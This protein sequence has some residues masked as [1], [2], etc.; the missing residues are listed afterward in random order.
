MD[1]LDLIKGQILLLELED[2]C[3]IG[4]ILHIGAKKSFVRL[5]NVRDFQSNLP[6][7]GN[8]DYYSSEIR[9]IKII[10]QSDP[11]DPCNASSVVS[12]TAAQSVTRI[13][14]DDVQEIF[15]RINAHVF[16]HQTDMKYHD[17]IKYLKT[18]KL[19]ALTMEGIAGGRHASA[20]SLLSISTL[21]R[22]YVFDVMWMN[23]PNDLRMILAS[24]KVRRVVHNGRLLEDVLKHRYGAPL[25]KCFDTLVAHVSTSYDD[26]S[27]L[28][29]Q[30]CLSKYL[31]LPNNFFDGNITFAN[32][33]LNENQRKAAAK[34]VAFLLALQDYLVHEVML[35][36]FY[37]SCNRYGAS[38][39]A[40]DEH[41]TSILKLSKGRNEDL[42]DI[43]RFKLNLRQSDEH[44]E[45]CSTPTT[46]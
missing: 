14:L 8:Q 7:R 6:I 34:N 30:Q 22:I 17:A 33:P 35:E 12:T 40:G 26:Q 31:N 32:R 25:G 10:E 2:E 37:Q 5:Q 16:I 13:D 20:P 4:E 29:I 19:I 3:V 42:I 28:T 27:E 23:V 43:D 11:V 45:E 24:S 18:Q 15:D 36:P 39:A 1:K 21:E 9:S 38:L 41:Y 44:K 46:V